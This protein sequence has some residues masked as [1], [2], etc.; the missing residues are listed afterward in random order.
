MNYIGKRID[1][2][3]NAAGL[4]V[5]NFAQ[6]TNNKQKNLSNVILGRNRP[7]Y[8][9]V[10]N[11]CKNIPFIKGMENINCKWIITGE[12]EMFNDQ[13]KINAI[14]QSQKEE[15]ERQKEK[16]KQL[17]KEIDIVK[18]KLTDKEEIIRLQNELMREYKER[19]SQYE[20]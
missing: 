11:L 13:K 17:N 7:S 19:Y 12:G 18:A 9:V 15:I 8:E 4:S 16:I 5:S 20:D 3:V 10:Y 1:K 2:L 14:H 6:K